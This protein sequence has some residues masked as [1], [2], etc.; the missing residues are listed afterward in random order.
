M[1]LLSHP[2]DLPIREPLILSMTNMIITKGKEDPIEEGGVEGAV[3]MNGVPE[4]GDAGEEAAVG[5]AGTVGTGPEI[6]A[7]PSA[8]VAG[9]QILAGVEKDNGLDIK[10]VVCEVEVIYM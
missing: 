7:G 6:R 4:E 9:L 3:E 8:A 5:I 10:R 2:H 1:R